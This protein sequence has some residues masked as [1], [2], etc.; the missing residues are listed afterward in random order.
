MA[1]EGSALSPENLKIKSNFIMGTGT[2]GHRRKLFCIYTGKKLKLPI[3][4]LTY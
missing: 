4:S 3:Y 2:Q 1:L